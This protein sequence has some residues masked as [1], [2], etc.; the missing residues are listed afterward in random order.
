MK[1]HG[2]KRLKADLTLLFVA[3][4]WGSAFAAQ[5]VASAHLGFFLFNGLRFLVGALTV[6]AIILIRREGWLKSIT[7]IEWISGILGGLIIFIGANTQQAG[8]RFTTAGKA[9]FITGL[10]VILVPI[11]LTLNEIRLSLFKGKQHIPMHWSVW[12]ASILAVAGL[13]L[14]SVAE[15]FSLSMGDAIILAGTI[16]WAG[17]IL[18]IGRF[19]NRVN[20]LRFAFVQYLVSAVINLACGLFFESSTLPGLI[21]AWWTVLYVGVFSVGIAYT[22]QVE[23]QKTAPETDASLIL[24]LEAVFGALSGWIFLREAMTPVQLIGCVLMLAG[25]ILAQF[26]SFSERRNAAAAAVLEFPSGVK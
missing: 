12:A 4:I 15:T 21:P 10:Y 5:R 1:D 6:L 19:T 13:Y 9:G 26:S 16:F 24:C 17:H 23:G 18:L 25:M 2:T 14:L 3:I 8:I 11:I 22:L 20:T 7:R